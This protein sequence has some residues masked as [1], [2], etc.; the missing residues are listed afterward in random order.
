MGEFSGHGRGP[1][2]MGGK[3]FRPNGLESDGSNP[4]DI[5]AS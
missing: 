4:I 2:I 3:D 1:G 5:S